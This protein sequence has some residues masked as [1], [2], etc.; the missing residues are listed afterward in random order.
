MELKYLERIIAKANKVMGKEVAA[1]LTTKKRK[2]LKDSSFCGPGR[3][4]PVN[5]CAHYTAA[6]RLL[7]RSKF[8]K[9]TKDK[10]RACINSKGKSLK[11]GGAKKAA[12]YV[13][14]V[15]I[16]VDALINSDIFGTTLALVNDSIVQP[17]QDLC[18]CGNG[19]CNCKPDKP[20]NPCECDV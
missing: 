13:K 7:N 20:K 15:G 1:P 5:D 10:I 4:F 16:D 17:D 11:C 8:S 18:D 6:L 9:S 3:S 19:P 14:E 12:A 2:G